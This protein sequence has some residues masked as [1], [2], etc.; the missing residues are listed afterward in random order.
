MYNM[1]Y[2]HN[3]MSNEMNPIMR[4]T[5]VITMYG[6]VPMN[7]IYKLADSILHIRWTMGME[8]WLLPW[9]PNIMFTGRT[10]YKVGIHGGVSLATP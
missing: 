8:M 4:L 1:A 10:F 6:W 9:R 2:R 7:V 3:L 5:Y